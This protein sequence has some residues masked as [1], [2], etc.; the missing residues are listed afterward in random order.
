MTGLVLVLYIR[1]ERTTIVNIDVISI[2]SSQLLKC[3][4]SIFQM[5]QIADDLIY[6]QVVKEQHASKLA[7][8][9]AGITVHV[10]M[11]LLFISNDPHASAKYIFTVLN[12]K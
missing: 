8:L 12:S 2:F 10:S 1:S 5:R 11:L 3:L 7:S 6:G 4:N 9:K